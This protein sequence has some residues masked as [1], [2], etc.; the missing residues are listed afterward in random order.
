MRAS[1]SQSSL[2]CMFSAFK[3]SIEIL[4]F[5]NPGG[6][7]LLK[8]YHGSNHFLSFIGHGGTTN[9]CYSV[10]HWDYV[11]FYNVQGIWRAETLKWLNNCWTVSKRHELFTYC[12][13]NLSWVL[14]SR[15]RLCCSKHYNSKDWDRRDE[16]SES[17][18]KFIKIPLKYF[19]HQ[20]TTL[21]D[22]TPKENERIGCLV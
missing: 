16:C 18:R 6:F 8:L 12:K 15:Y 3:E 7:V 9:Y 2:C 10:L 22:R 1:R 21:I 5:R 20:I 17:W 14:M 11:D 13:W 19:P 4:L